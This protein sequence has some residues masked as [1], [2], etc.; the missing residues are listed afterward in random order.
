M[1]CGEFV[2][3]MEWNR[4]YR[5]TR[6]GSGKVGE[7]IEEG[8]WGWKRGFKVGFYFNTNDRKMEGN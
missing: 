8:G 5:R 3:L 1:T 6:G 7:E 4:E 2:V